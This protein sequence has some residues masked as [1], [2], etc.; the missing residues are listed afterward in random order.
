MMILRALGRYSHYALEKKAFE[1]LQALRTLLRTYAFRAWAIL[2]D[3][4][5]RD[6]PA[7]W[8]VEV[9]QEAPA[10]PSHAEWLEW[11]GAHHRK[12]ILDD[13]AT[14][15]DQENG[16]WLLLP[17]GNEKER[18]GLWIVR[19]HQYPFG[20]SLTLRIPE[21]TPTEVWCLAGDFLCRFPKLYLRMRFHDN[22]A[23]LLPTTL[24]KRLLDHWREMASVGKGDMMGIHDQPA[25]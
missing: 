10:L 14:V 19:Q 15:T 22:V 18:K 11:F 23:I 20:F 4:N 17:H 1:E 24:W 7:E 8:E 9:D 25:G 2:C 6:S 12:M 13:S 3:L 21:G 5:H 16:W